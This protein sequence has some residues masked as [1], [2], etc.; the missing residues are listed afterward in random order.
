MVPVLRAVF[1]RRAALTSGR[2]DIIRASPESPERKTLENK[3]VTFCG[4]KSTFRIGLVTGS[5]LEIILEI[6]ICRKYCIM[7][8]VTK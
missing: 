2:R 1:R 7:D 3:A 5:P 4:D 6:E 8:R